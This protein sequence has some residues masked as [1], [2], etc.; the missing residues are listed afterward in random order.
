MNAFYRYP[1]N[2]GLHKISHTLLWDYDLKNFDWFKCRAEVVKRVIE[3][4]RLSDFFAAFDLYGGVNAVR[5]IAKDEV[6]ELSDRNLDFMCQAFK[7]KKED[8]LCYKKKQ[9]RAKLL[10]F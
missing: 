10:N 6:N 2:K 9:S 3:M 7:L 1:E 8:T 5:M 4:G